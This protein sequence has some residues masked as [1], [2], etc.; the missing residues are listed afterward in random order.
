M[1]ERK[2]IGDNPLDLLVPRKKPAT[3]KATAKKKASAKTTPT[4]KGD[5]KART[6]GAATP[7]PKKVPT[8]AATKVGKKSKK[9][10][11]A[12]TKRKTSKPSAAPRATAAVD[13][14]EAASLEAQAIEAPE[15]SEPADAAPSETTPERTVSLPR[16]SASPGQYLTF[17]LA[18]E[19]YGSAILGVKEIIEYDTLTTVPATPPWVRGVI[20]LRGSVVPVIDLAVKFGLPEIEVT[21]RTC[22]VIVEVELDGEL[23]VMGILADAVSQVVDFSADDI[24]PAPAFGTQI[25]VDYLLGMGKLSEK[26]VL[27]LNKDRVLSLGELMTMANSGRAPGPA[28]GD[29]EVAPQPSP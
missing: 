11:A 26:F 3:K 16:Q 13:T 17:F 22:I 2:S 15:Q 25:H 29:L 8:P 12:E 24:E 10:V 19:E 1:A 20:N 18:G 6:R 5:V 27:L 7:R 23:A 14:P 28:Q 21:K 9:A 4:K